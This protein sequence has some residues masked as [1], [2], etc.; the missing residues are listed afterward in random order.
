MTQARLR[1][2]NVVWA[3][4]YLVLLVATPP[5]RANGA[6]GNLRRLPSELRL[7]KGGG[8]DPPPSMPKF[9]SR[10]DGEIISV[11]QDAYDPRPASA[12]ATRRPSRLL[13]P[14]WVAGP[15]RRAPNHDAM[16]ER[17]AGWD[18]LLQTSANTVGTLLAAVVI[19]VV[20]VA[21]GAFEAYGVVNTLLW[22][23]GGL[24]VLVVLIGFAW[25]AVREATR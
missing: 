24:S 2:P 6:G 25:T 10:R 3:A 16:R 4:G 22:I 21:A 15:T 12:N 23:A 7:G 5:G 13:R 14:D 8:P 19:Y 11:G 1:G 9:R 17:S 18:W 20:G